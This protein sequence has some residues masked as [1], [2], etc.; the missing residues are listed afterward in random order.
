M[1][2]IL[3]VIASFAGEPAIQTA[4]GGSGGLFHQ[5]TLSQ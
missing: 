1:A 4:A 2:R 3:I 5:P